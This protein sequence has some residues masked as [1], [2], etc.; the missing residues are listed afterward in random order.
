MPEEDSDPRPYHSPLRERQAAGTRE[1]ILQA[2][3]ELI[4]ED[5]LAD[6]AMRDVASRAGVAERTVYY[7]FPSREAVLDGLAEWVD[8]QLRD[9]KLQADPRDLEDVPRRAGELFAAF[10][11]IGAPA[12]AMARLSTA[13][14]IRSAAW[15]ERTRAFRER[16][17][18]LLDPLPDDEAA[19][20]YAILRHLLSATTWWILRQD[21]DLDGDDSAAAVAWAVESLLET[22]RAD[23]AEGRA[24]ALHD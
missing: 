17:A 9:L 7:H 12:M 3:A 8:D 16:F 11:R 14:G 5:G 1:D 19:Q 23:V 13:R 15:H 18:D 24:S 21:F 4:L 22:M 10:E 20:R 6:F 2:A